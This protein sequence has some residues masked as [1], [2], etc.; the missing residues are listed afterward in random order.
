MN[1]ES[2][3][4]DMLTTSADKKAKLF[5]FVIQIQRYLYLK[6]HMSSKQKSVPGRTPG[7]VSPV[8]Q[9]DG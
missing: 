7:F 1:L 8:P 6:V 3:F 5:V 9:S 2:K 4:C